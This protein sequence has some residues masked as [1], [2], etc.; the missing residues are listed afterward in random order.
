LI[1]IQRSSCSD[2]LNCNDGIILYNEYKSMEINKA[3]LIVDVQNDFC[4]GGALGVQNGNSVV[5]V[6]NRYIEKFGQAGMPIFL[7]RDW[8]PPRTSHFNTAGGLWPPHCIQGS[9]GAEFHPDL[10]ISNEAVVV[11]KGTA[12]DEDSYSAFAAADARDVAL[13]DLLRQRGVERIYVGGLAT[14]Y[15]VKETVLEGLMQGFQV[16]L[17]HDAICGVNLQPE[18]SARAIEAMVK[19]G[20]A[21]APSVDSFRLE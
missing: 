18:D 13:K 15:C 16:V 11:S 14:D 1:G 20:V 12:V 2:S 10:R 9:K 7:T 6:L 4:P 17:L 21:V 3:L 8:H 5:P 19:A